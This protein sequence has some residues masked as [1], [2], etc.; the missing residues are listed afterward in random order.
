[1]CSFDLKR[2]STQ[3]TAQPISRLTNRNKIGYATNVGGIVS[4]SAASYVVSAIVYRNKTAG[5][6]HDHSL[7]MNGV[8]VIL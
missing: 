4:D 8:R 5:H 2:S 3:R 6:S 7:S 1:M